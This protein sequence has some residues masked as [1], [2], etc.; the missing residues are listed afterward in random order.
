MHIKATF[1]R[2]HHDSHNLVHNAA[3]QAIYFN[4]SKVIVIIGVTGQQVSIS[5]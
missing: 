5:L 2:L 4:M 1:Q 3:L